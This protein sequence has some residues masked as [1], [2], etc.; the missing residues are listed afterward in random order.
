L[1]KEDIRKQ[2]LL[3]L[4]SEVNYL[5]LLEHSYEMERHLSQNTPETRLEY[6]S[7][8]IFNF[9]TY[10]SEMSC[11][12]GEKAVEVC[13]A[14]NNGKTFDYIEDEENYKWYLLMCN[15]PFFAN[16]TEWG[17]SVRGA[18]WGPLRVGTPIELSSCGLWIGDE[19]RTEWTF[20]R[21]EWEEFISAIIE[22]AKHTG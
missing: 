12:F 13:T 3:W 5:E 17:C 9:T 22:F 20:T 8:N 19:Q 10:D 7:E 1:A 11:L 18:W 6:L 4:L 15:M 2:N 14:I 21:E 16:R